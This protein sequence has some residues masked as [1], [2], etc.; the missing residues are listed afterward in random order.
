MSKMVV[1]WVIIENP[2]LIGIGLVA[3][4]RKGNERM[5]TSG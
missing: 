4:T 3:K 2:S 1:R 5:K